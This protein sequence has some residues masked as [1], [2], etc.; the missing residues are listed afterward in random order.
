MLEA[1]DRK[2]AV[3]WNIAIFQIFYRREGHYTCTKFC[4]SWRDPRQ[5]QI[6]IASGLSKCT[7]CRF[8]GS[9]V[10]MEFKAPSNRCLTHTK[11]NCGRVCALT[12]QTSWRSSYGLV[13][14]AGLGGFGESEVCMPYWHSRTKTQNK[15]QFWGV[16]FCVV[17]GNR[18]TL[19]YVGKPSWS[20]EP[21]KFHT[22]ESK[23]L[24]SKIR[25]RAIKYRNWVYEAKLATIRHCG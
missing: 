15:K 9:F 2:L 12:R 16:I 13:T 24:K 25:N 1:G 3:I 19:T 8:F 5:T 20:K 7:Y 21:K 23:K 22:P 14:S 10:N 18:I 6:A 17:Q 4:I 11:G